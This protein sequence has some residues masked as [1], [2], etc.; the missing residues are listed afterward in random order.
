MKP[1]V[2]D[3]AQY[4]PSVPDICLDN[5][6]IVPINRLSDIVPDRNHAYV[7][8]NDDIYALNHEGTQVIK[9]SSSSSIGKDGESAYQIAVARGFQGTEQEWL[10]SLDGPPGDDGLSA[11][12]VAL[13]SGFEGTEQ[14]WLDSLDGPPGSQGLSAYEVAVNNGFE[15]TEQEWLDYDFERLKA[16]FD[17]KFG[18]VLQSLDSILGV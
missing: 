18:A 10:D 16:Y 1:S 13:K 17:P 4:T 7:L 6:V 2:C 12:E 9:I 8:P 14:E 5:Y 3:S 15:G 11:Y